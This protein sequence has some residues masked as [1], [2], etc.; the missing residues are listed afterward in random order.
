VIYLTVTPPTT[1]NDFWT[2]LATT[3]AKSRTVCY[4]ANQNAKWS[5]TIENHAR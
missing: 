5:T 4:N 3:Q 1:L 2:L